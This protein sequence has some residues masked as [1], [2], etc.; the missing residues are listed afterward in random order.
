MCGDCR[1]ILETFDENSFDSV[2]TDPPYEL[3]F[4]G[5]KWDGS[6]ISYDGKVWKE[7]LR[8]LKPGGYLLSFGGSRTYHRLACKIEDVGFE[9]HPLIGWCYGCL[10]EDS[11][12]LTE[13]GWKLGINISKDDK[14]MTWDSST[15]CLKLNIVE[16]IFVAPFNGELISFK[17]DNT[18]QLVTPNHRVYKKHL[19]RKQ[20]DGIRRTRFE[21]NWNVELAEDIN[22]WNPIKLPLAGIHDGNGIGGT[23]YAKL[24]GWIWTEGSFDKQPGYTGVR[25]YQSSVNIGNVNKIDELVKKFVPKY[26]RYE[27]TRLYK[28]REYVE[29]SWYFAG[30]VAKKI[31]E[32]LPDKHPT[33]NLMWRMS[34]N[35]TV[36]FINAAMDGDGSG[37]AFYQNNMEDLIWFQTILHMINMQ[38]RI[39]SKKMCVA[40]HKNST[41][42]LQGK[43]L[44][45]SNKVSYDGFVWCVKVPSGAFVA[46]RNGKIFITGN[47][48]FPKA[49]NLS[50]QIDKAA[51]TE[52]TDLAKKWD[53]WFYGKQSLK[54]ALEPICMAQKPIENISNVEFG[55]LSGWKYM[56]TSS[57]VGN[58]I[59]HTYRS[60]NPSN[61]SYYEIVDKNGE[62]IER[63]TLPFKVFDVN[64]IG[65]IEKWGVGAVNVDDC[66]IGSNGGCK[67]DISYV[68]CQQEIYGSGLNNQHSAQVANLG[69]FPS[70]LILGHSENYSSEECVE[71]CPIKML[72]K[73]SGILKSGARTGHRT[74]PKTK[75]TYG[76]FKIKDESP[77]LA[78]EGGSSR[79]FYQVEPDPLFYCAKA[80]KKERGVNNVHPT[81]K[82]LKLMRYLVRLVTPP[83][84]TVL[85]PFAGSGTTL[86]AA[87]EENFNAVGIE[88]DEDY[89]K[90]AIE[91]GCG[92]EL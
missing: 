18:D 64:M 57:S 11:E 66:R 82:P 90:I 9:L 72:D 67:S 53:G 81:I 65:N 48:G 73:Q 63:D 43:H 4:M 23:E 22:R 92:M 88:L 56:C 86:L 35:E 20:E 52:R 19:L 41:T 45:R 76:S 71:G 7:V 75:N 80:S 89:I 83:G 30:D 50:K 28:N 37:M 25:I 61:N 39:N 26:S 24:L 6:G 31:R 12:I 36:E 16:D 60:C 78:S 42:E 84:G 27:R 10:S 44:K 33:F 34:Y 70:N 58:N 79:F 54:P 87:K 77:S 38:G 21:E 29:Y 17:N 69:R 68:P 55:K 13:D 62:I 85:D 46:K 2:V 1:E 3:K 32:D 47:S 14:V 49:T 15:K 59:K 91:R 51:G 8:V 5:K 40:L 74:Y